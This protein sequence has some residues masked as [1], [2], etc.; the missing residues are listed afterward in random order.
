MAFG[1]CGESTVGDGAEP[2]TVEDIES[3][4]NDGEGEDVAA[5][6]RPYGVVLLSSS[7]GKGDEDMLV[8]ETRG[9]SWTVYTRF[10]VPS[11]MKSSSMS[12]R[13]SGRTHARAA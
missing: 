8:L 11:T 7:M 1:A 6:G 12:I 2:A 3:S 13:S 10:H 9:W 5:D 4:D